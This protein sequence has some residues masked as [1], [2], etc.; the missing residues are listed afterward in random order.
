MPTQWR[1]IAPIVGR[2]AA[3][4]LERSDLHL[5]LSI[6]LSNFLIINLPPSFSFRPLSFYPIP[7]YP[8]HF[9]FLPFYS[10]PLH[11]LPFYPHPLPLGWCAGMSRCWIWHRRRRRGWTQQTIQGSSN[12]VHTYIAVLQKLLNLKFQQV[13]IFADDGLL[14][15]DNNSHFFCKEFFINEDKN[16]QLLQGF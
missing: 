9:Y 6:Y 2:T 4:C 7:F 5:P 11:P 12:Q 15:A 3:Q 13:E 8:L 16:K 14:S 1:T 10:F